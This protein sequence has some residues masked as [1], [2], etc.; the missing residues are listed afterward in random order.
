MDDTEGDLD[1]QDRRDLAAHECLETHR[2]HYMKSTLRPEAPA[3][4]QAILRAIRLLKTFTSERPELS[5]TE[6]QKAAEL[7][8]PTAHRLLSALQSEGLVGRSS[9]DGHFHLGPAL[10]ALGRQAS[11]NS[12]LRAMV[13]PTLE[14]LSRDTGEC[15][16][17]EVWVDDSMLIFDAVEGSFVVTSN[18][19]IGTRWPLHATSTGK[20]LL[21]TLTDE[22]LGQVLGDESKRFTDRTITDRIQLREDLQLSA[23]QGYATAIEELE[24]DY[25][26][27][28]AGFKDSFGNFE[29]AIS[30]G[31]P[32]SRFDAKRVSVMGEV[33]RAAAAKLSAR[34]NNS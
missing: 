1:H 17:L 15:S 5:L 10:I 16:T 28:A 20:C 14:R 18:L 32:A 34:H 6:L 9:T 2:F 23:R 22:Q 25:V 27:V 31:G 29:G 24:A 13:R 7:T 11:L 3:G 4:T 8:K 33:V 26:A 21:T 19:G 12:D 30:I